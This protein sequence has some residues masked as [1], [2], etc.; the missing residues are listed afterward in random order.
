MP[1]GVHKVGG[2]FFSLLRFVLLLLAHIHVIIAVCTQILTQQQKR[3]SAKKLFPLKY[4]FTCTHWLFGGFASPTLAISSS[5]SAPSFIGRL[6][7]NA[8]LNWIYLFI[9]LSK[10]IKFHLCIYIYSIVIKH[11]RTTQTQL[12]TFL[13]SADE[14]KISCKNSIKF[15]DDA[16]YD[17]KLQERF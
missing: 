3:Q 9:F 11:S 17:G 13:D 1:L 14:S 12:F 10:R 7:D 4:F 6:L 2:Q 16:G 8:Q 15:S 5:S